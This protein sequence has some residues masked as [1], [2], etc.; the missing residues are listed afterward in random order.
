MNDGELMT[1]IHHC[2]KTYKLSRNTALS[3]PTQNHHFGHKNVSI[4]HLSAVC[5]H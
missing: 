1:I 3:A 5:S 2:H 4:R